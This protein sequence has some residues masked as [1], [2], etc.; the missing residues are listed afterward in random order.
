MGSINPN[1]IKGEGGGA[2]FTM[3]LPPYCFFLLKLEVVVMTE[4]AS[5]REI[6]AML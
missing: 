1:S 2:T 5:N 3:F 4:A 6:I